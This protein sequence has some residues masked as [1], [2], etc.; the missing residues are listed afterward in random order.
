VNVGRREPRV[1]FDD[2]SHNPVNDLQP[3]ALGERDEI[4]QVDARRSLGGVDDGSRMRVR[5]G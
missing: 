3:V 5:G 2:R 4:G 1:R